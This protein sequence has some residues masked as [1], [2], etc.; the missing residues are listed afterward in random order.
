MP[1]AAGRGRGCRAGGAC[2]QDQGRKEQP[3]DQG[4]RESLPEFLC[5]ILQVGRV[6]HRA[7]SVQA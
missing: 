6:L 2:T 7:W 4:I 1:A 3:G 5:G